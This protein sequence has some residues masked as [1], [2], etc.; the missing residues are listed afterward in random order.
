MGIFYSPTCKVKH[1]YCRV[2]K[3][4]MLSLYCV[5]ESSVMQGKEVL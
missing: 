4:E 3:S 5:L 1:K 2:T